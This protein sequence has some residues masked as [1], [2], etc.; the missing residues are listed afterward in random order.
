MESAEYTQLGNRG[1]WGSLE[2]RNKSKSKS[3]VNS[4]SLYSLSLQN[5]EAEYKCWKKVFNSAQQAQTCVCVQ[6]AGGTK[7]LQ[8]LYLHSSLGVPQIGMLNNPGT[9]DT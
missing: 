2:G 3:R 6:K 7:Y 8:N 5:S 9:A 4:S 1:A